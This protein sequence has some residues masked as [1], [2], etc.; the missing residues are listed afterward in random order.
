MKKIIGL[1]IIMIVLGGCYS[2]SVKSF[3]GG[4]KC[5]DKVTSKKIEKATKIR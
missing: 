3:V 4:R 1:L 2:H 5:G